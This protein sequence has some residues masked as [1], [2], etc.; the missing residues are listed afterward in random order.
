MPTAPCEE[1]ARHALQDQHLLQG[2]CTQCPPVLGVSPSS[3]ISRNRRSAVGRSPLAWQMDM[4]V[5]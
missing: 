5:E 4:R 1:P 3:C 2:L